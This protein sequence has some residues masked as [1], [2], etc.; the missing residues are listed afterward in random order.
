MLSLTRRREESLL[1]YPSSL[2]SH[3]YS[4]KEA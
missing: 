3:K 2:L 4:E 1:I